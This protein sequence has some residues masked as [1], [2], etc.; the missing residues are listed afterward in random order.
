MP[1]PSLLLLWPQVGLGCSTYCSSN[2]KT[3]IERHD[4]TQMTSSIARM[5]DPFRMITEKHPNGV[6]YTVTWP[7]H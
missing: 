6:I 5:G 4:G 2:E 7:P 1:Y 3:E